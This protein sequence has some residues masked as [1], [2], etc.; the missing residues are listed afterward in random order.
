MKTL[1]LI[2]LDGY[3]NIGL[4]F[5]NCSE[6]YADKLRI[7]NVDYGV[8][9]SGQAY[10]SDFTNLSIRPNKT[11]YEMVGVANSNHVNKGSCLGI[12]GVTYGVVLDSVNNV[13]ILL[14]SFEKH[15]VGIDMSGN[16]NTAVIIGVRLESMDI[17][18]D[19]TGS[20][21]EVVLGVHYSNVG[22]TKKDN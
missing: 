20:S 2:P 21:N 6:C 13:S 18:I 11:C 14:T 1:A 8:F 5:E 16:V 9:I 15:K 3:N 12:Q 22:I 17:G 7:G 10:Y 19:A 4:D